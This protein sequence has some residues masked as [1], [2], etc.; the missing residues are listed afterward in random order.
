MLNARLVLLTL[1]LFKHERKDSI[2]L[3]TLFSPF[4]CIYIVL[5]IYPGGF[6]GKQL[7]KA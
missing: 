6:Q 2:S 4:R 3:L 5:T 7:F 1:N